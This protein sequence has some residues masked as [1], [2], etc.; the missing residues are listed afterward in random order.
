MRV[1]VCVCGW[2]GERQSRR[3]PAIFAPTG[4]RVY[5]FTN[6]HTHTHTHK[7]IHTH[8]DTHASTC[9]FLSL[10]FS[11]PPSRTRALTV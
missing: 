11:L 7:R 6:T 1:C 10:S 8:V 2:E 9:V 5:R 4:L 3:L